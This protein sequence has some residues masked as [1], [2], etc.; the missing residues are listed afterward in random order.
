MKP[1]PGERRRRLARG[2]FAE[3][4]AALALRLK[5]Y[6]ILAMRHRTRLGEIDIVARRGDT[7]AIVEVKARASV[8]AAIDAVGPAARRRIANAADLWLA[9]RPDAARLSLRFDIVA[10]RP[11]RWPVHL[12][13]AF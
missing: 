5:G 2:A 9:G 4:L 1:S 3:D 6:R 11:W 12:P 8:R 13:G 7:V 10:V